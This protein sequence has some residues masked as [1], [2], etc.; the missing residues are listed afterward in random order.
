MGGAELSLV[1]SQNLA[2]FLHLFL[3]H[4]R[5]GPNTRVP[6]FVPRGRTGDFCDGWIPLELA[7]EAV[8]HGLAH[9][10]KNAKQLIKSVNQW[11]G[12]LGLNTFPPGC[13]TKVDNLIWV[14]QD[15]ELAQLIKDSGLLDPVY[16]PKCVPGHCNVLNLD[17]WDIRKACAG[18]LKAEQLQDMDAYRRKL[19]QAFAAP[20]ALQAPPSMVSSLHTAAVAADLEQVQS[21][22]A[23]GAQANACNDAGFTALRAAAAAS[24]T[25]SL[26][27]RQRLYS[28]IEHLAAAGAD[29]TATDTSDRAALEARVAELQHSNQ[30]LQEQ[31]T[32]MQ[33]SASQAQQ[34]GPERDAVHAALKEALA[35]AQENVKVWLSVNCREPVQAHDSGSETVKKC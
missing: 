35:K 19:E 2:E 10:S 21:L 28:V 16:W 15:L 7:Y 8:K 34:W 20:L 30:Q 23:G 14:G 17:S 4:H 9:R 29:T 13:L 12:S 18:N 33:G 24:V 27:D 3:C 32:E 25:A 11:K 22:L 1:R 31:L 26:E 6:P 5:T